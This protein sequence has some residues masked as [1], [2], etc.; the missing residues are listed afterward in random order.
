MRRTIALAAL[1]LAIA[2][3]LIVPLAFGG[4]DALRLLATFPPSG[5]LALGL[6]AIIGWL[7]KAAKFR[8]L[9]ARLGQPTGFLPC[10]AISLGCDFA[11]AATPAGL[12]GYAATV[13]LFGRVGVTPACAAAVAAADQALDLIFFAVAIPLALLW[14]LGYQMFEVSV[15]DA[16]VA[17]CWS[18]A[19]AL[20]CLVVK[21]VGRARRQM[22]AEAVLR[23][24]GLRGRRESVLA[25][26]AEWR[27]HLRD[28]CGAPRAFAAAALM[29]TCMQ[30]IA[31]YS[32][33]AL[34]LSWSGYEAP[35]AAILLLQALALHAGQWTGIPGGI[36][37]T[38]VIIGKTLSVWAPIVTVGSSVMIWR[39]ATF[40]LTL[41]VG[42]VAFALIAARNGLGPV[43]RRPNTMRSELS[44]AVKNT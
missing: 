13:F 15:A 9:A 6:V 24:P 17:V 18:I 43:N 21:C 25:V 10:V 12:G 8:L 42:G 22:F 28:L 26:L 41:L 7:A 37:S 33:L 11:F 27:D 32:I 23:L 5:F 39:M 16:M 40:D 44:S 34:I 31:R 1:L 19:I 29:A 30:W 2:G 20:I 14:M 3:S 4:R 38:D 36:G 35:F